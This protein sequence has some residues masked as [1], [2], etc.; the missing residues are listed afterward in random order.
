[1]KRHYFLWSC[2]SFWKDILKFYEAI[3]NRDMKNEVFTLSVG[4]G[5]TEQ[6]F[7]KNMRF[8]E[9]T[10]TIIKQRE[11]ILF[12]GQYNMKQFSFFL[13]FFYSIRG[14]NILIDGKTK[15]RT[16]VSESQSETKRC[17]WNSNPPNSKEAKLLLNQSLGQLISCWLIIKVMPYCLN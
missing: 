10:T 15:R 5:E 6:N 8:L 1:M 7:K 11:T 2:F 4:N 17:C 12:R 3:H 14:W 16:S 9:L 13:R